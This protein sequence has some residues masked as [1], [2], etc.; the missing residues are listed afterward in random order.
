MKRHHGR[1]ARPA[2]RRGRRRYDVKGQASLDNPNR[3]TRR[4][5]RRGAAGWKAIIND[6]LTL[7]MRK[8]FDDEL[9]LMLKGMTL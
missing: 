4:R 6:M 2:R 5:M 3:L 9:M 7:E 8:R 1:P